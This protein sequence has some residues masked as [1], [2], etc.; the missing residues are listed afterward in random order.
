MS[1]SVFMVFNA[2]M[3]SQERVS[4]QN[5]ADA[6]AY[7][8]AVLVARD[9]NFQAYTNRAMVAN[10]IAMAQY[11]GL[12]S[13][14]KML[15]VATENLDTY[16]GWIP[17]VGWIIGVVDAVM[18]A[19]DGVAQ[20]VLEGMTT[21]TNFYTAALSKGQ[22]IFRVG[23]SLSSILVINDVVKANDPKINF[24]AAS[25]SLFI[26]D[27]ANTWYSFTSRVDTGFDSNDFNEERR[28]EFHKVTTNSRDR[29]TSRRTYDWINVEVPFVKTRVEKAGGSD[30]ID[31]DD[32]ETWT[33]MD[34]VSLTVNTWYCHPFHCGWHDG[35]EIP[36]GYASTTAGEDYG[37]NRK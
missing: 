4:L 32:Q 37:M 31:T 27:S 11:V 19:V 23:M 18:A 21:V 13:W 33:A 15:A 25:Q 7:S 28:E 2:G 34:T 10:Q 17:V 9:L 14:I 12:S 22:E 16:F 3:L 35:P 26:G 6:A 5:T 29:F 8:S 30:L 36:F 20:P 1:L 24:N